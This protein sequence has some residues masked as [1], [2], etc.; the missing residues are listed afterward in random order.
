MKGLLS[1][2]I[3]ASVAVSMA[4]T[5]SA[6]AEPQRIVSL[7]LCTDQILL[8][9]V[10]RERIAALSFLAG[11]ATM[12]PRVAD[13]KGL[14]LVQGAAEEVLT[15]DPDLILAG[16]SST[17]ATVNLLERLGRRVVKVPMASSFEEIRVAVRLV[18]EAVGE[19]ERGRTVIANFDRR[20]AAA[21]STSDGKSPSIVAMQV[22]SLASGP[23]SL[24]DEVFSAAGYHNMARDAEAAGKLG[25]AGRLPLE[26]LLLQPPDLVV[27]ANAPG[28]FRTVLGDNLRHPAFEQL[29]R[30]HPNVH[31][32]MSTWLCGTPAI[33]EAVERLAAVRGTLSTPPRSGP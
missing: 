4:L 27:L 6:A 21:S 19:P 18:A 31:L 25:P 12:S 23:G 14:P 32:P 7:N 9:L 1:V 13:A 29:L 20:L 11:D 17:P 5:L 22:N 26:T 28:D 3:F 10:P 8:D 30:N 24:L 33:A 15:F 16:T 2:R